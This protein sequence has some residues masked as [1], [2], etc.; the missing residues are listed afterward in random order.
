MLYPGYDEKLKI[1]NAPY[2]LIYFANWISNTVS[3]NKRLFGYVE[4]VDFVPDMESSFFFTKIR[5]I[6]SNEL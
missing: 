6:I 3:S 5:L 1:K 4:Q 2:M